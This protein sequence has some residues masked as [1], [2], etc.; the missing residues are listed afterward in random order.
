[1]RG[2]FRAC[3][4]QPLGVVLAQES[5]R[6]YGEKC[7]LGGQR[8]ATPCLLPCS[9][10]EAQELRAAAQEAADRLAA[11]RVRQHTADERARILEERLGS[12]TPRPSWRTTAPFDVAERPGCSTQVRRM[13]AG[14]TWAG[15][16]VG[17]WIESHV[18][19]WRT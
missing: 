5:I 14:E 4:K 6:G 13:D 7:L 9:A 16:S 19:L 12:M 10:Q 2:A 18:M 11:A 3:D 8:P 17:V 15:L 1:M